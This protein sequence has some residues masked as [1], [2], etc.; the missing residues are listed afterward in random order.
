MRWFLIQYVGDVAAYVQPQVVDRFYEL[1]KEIKK[2]VWTTAN[3][4]YREEEYRDIIVVG[5]SLGSVV[6]YDVL[7]HRLA[8]SFDAVADG[9]TVDDV[10]VTLLTTVPAPRPGDR[11]SM[12]NGEQSARWAG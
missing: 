10:I 12:Q 2:C 6:A 1:R 3:A 11:P 4:V 8:L 7:N 5:H 9:V